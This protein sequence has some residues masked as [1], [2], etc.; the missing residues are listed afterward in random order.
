MPEIFDTTTLI[1]IAVAV[2]VLLRLRS[3]LGKRTGYQHPPPEDIDQLRKGK[4]KANPKEVKNVDNVVSLPDRS[5]AKRIKLDKNPAIEAI[6]K[7]AKTGTKLNTALKE[8][9]AGTP[10]FEPESFLSGARMA[11]ELIVTAFANGDKKS[12]KNLLSPEVYDGFS[13]AI[14]DRVAKGEKVQST[15]VGIEK[16]MIKAAEV[17]KNDAQITVQFISQIVSA[18]LDKNDEIVDGDP[19]QVVEVNDIWTF[20]RTIGSKDPNWKLVA[21]ESE[22]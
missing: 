3:V 22:V 8:V 1:T 6:D 17:T 11:Y 15:F 14:S 18:T 5:G 7:Y 21:T 19:D 20:A 12:L 10:G 4:T 2:F 16:S 9:A 13:S